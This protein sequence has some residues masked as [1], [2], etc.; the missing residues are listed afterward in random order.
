MCVYVFG[1]KNVF[2]KYI[3]TYTNAYIYTFLPKQTVS[4]DRLGETAV[5]PVS[6]I[7]VGREKSSL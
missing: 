4:Q 5:C 3:H 7:G 6:K 2:D 1:Y